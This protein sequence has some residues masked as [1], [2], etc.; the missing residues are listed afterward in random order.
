MK[1]TKLFLFFAYCIFDLSILGCGRPNQQNQDDK[2]IEESE[3]Q[4]KDSL[5]NLR[6]FVIRPTRVNG[7]D[8]L[9]RYSDKLAGIKIYSVWILD[10]SKDEVIE[11]QFTKY[12]IKID[13]QCEVPKITNLSRD[14]Q[15][16]TPTG[17]SEITIISNS[18]IIDICSD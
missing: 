16:S 15:S 4:K 14:F 11:V 10:S 3:K 7:T 12:K 1:L 9:I 13:P 6:T 18:D 5:A 2:I 17:D 8:C